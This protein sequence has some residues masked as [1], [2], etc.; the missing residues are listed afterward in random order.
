MLETL[1]LYI[2]QIY[3]V[4]FLFSK[5]LFLIDS[6]FFILNGPLIQFT[7][8]MKSELVFTKLAVRSQG[9]LGKAF[10][11]SFIQTHVIKLFFDK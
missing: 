11:L 1:G 6:V 8:S 5:V 3:N 10:G 2:I 9:R 7:I 4:L